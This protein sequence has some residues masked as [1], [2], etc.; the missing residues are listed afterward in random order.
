MGVFYFSD[1]TNEAEIRCISPG[2]MLIFVP[3]SDTIY[4]RASSK[5][6]EKAPQQRGYT[7]PL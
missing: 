4:T 6:K 1:G 2:I 3:V 5:K 7:A